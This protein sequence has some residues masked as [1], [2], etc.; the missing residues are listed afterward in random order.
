VRVYLDEGFLPADHMYLAT[1][2]AHRLYERLGF[3]RAAGPLHRYPARGI[4][5]GPRH[6]GAARD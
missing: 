4:H 1:C 6:R 2:A 3:T 5:N